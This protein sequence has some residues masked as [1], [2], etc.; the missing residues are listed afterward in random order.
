MQ[1]LLYKYFV[2]RYLIKRITKN[3]PFLVTTHGLYKYEGIDEYRYAKN[4]SDNN[5]NI[6]LLKDAI[7]LKHCKVHRS[8]RI[9][10]AWRL[11]W[12]QWLVSSARHPLLMSILIETVPYARTLDTYLRADNNQHVF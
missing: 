7:E 8:D 4:N 12:I 1:T 9:E 3:F 11:E 5:I 2:G 6:D 10:D